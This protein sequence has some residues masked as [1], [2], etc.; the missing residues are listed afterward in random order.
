M[1]G[2]DTELVIMTLPGYFA[3]S[4][5]RIAS[6][7]L[8]LSFLNIVLNIGLYYLTKLKLENQ[9]SILSFFSSA[10]WT[11]KKIIKSQSDDKGD[12]F[13]KLNHEYSKLSFIRNRMSRRATSAILEVD[14]LKEFVFMIFLIASGIKLGH[15]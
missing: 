13:S 10:L 7:F 14:Y 11:C 6:L 15:L 9:L 4:L 5:L 2:F 12:Y 1:S 3:T 8:I